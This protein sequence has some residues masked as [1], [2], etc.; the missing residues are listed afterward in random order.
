MKKDLVL[1]IIAS[2]CFIAGVTFLVLS[3]FDIWKLSLAFA[4]G[5]TGMA[6]ILLFI[7]NIKKIGKAKK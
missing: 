5:C 3:F 2:I 4:L 1:I 6:N 7:V